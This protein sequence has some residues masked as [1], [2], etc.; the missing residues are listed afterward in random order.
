MSKQETKIGRSNATKLVWTVAFL[1]V[2]VG[3]IML[4]IVFMTLSDIR[5]ERKNLD[6]IQAEMTHLLTSLDPHLARGRE[7]LRALL[8]GEGTGNVAG[9]WTM[10]LTSIVNDYTK[11]DIAG[12]PAIRWALNDCEDKVTTL[13]DI[14]RQCLRWAET[15]SAVVV[16]FPA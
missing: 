14:W 2:L 10:M 1:G 15:Y 16:A 9:E 4:G 13:K 5:D 7:E 3:V 12:D 11:R 8:D 6:A